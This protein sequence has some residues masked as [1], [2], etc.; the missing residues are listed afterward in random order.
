MVPMLSSA[1]WVYLYLLVA[2]F[3]GFSQVVGQLV[4]RLIS[5]R[6]GSND[7]PASRTSAPH[8]QVRGASSIASTASSQP[9]RSSDRSS[10]QSNCLRNRGSTSPAYNRRNRSWSGPGA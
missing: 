7:R 3:D 10:T 2:V 1:S 4:G 9:A 5:R 8:C 6:R